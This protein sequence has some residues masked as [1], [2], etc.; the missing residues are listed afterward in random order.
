[1]P[2]ALTCPVCQKT[3]KVPPNQADTRVYCSKKCLSKDLSRRFKG[4]TMVKNTIILQPKKNLDQFTTV[5]E[6]DLFK[7][8]SALS[9][10]SVKT[11]DTIFKLIVKQIRIECSNNNVVEIDKFM[12]F[13]QTATDLI[14]EVQRLKRFERRIRHDI[15]CDL[16][17]KFKDLKSLDTYDVV[18]SSEFDNS[19]EVNELNIQKIFEARILKKEKENEKV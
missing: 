11:I 12:T 16:H 4:K 6:G 13:R 7:K 8:V 17:E 1:M 9:G 3:F 5:T 2:V 15:K 10:V 14:T 18:Y 19:F